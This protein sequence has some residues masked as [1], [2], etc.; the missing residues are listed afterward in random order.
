MATT[1]TSKVLLASAV[2]GM[3][4]LT[5]FGASAEEAKSAKGE[6]V[7]CYGVNECKGH[8]ACAGPNGCA[9]KNDCKGQGFIDVDSKEACLKMEGGRLT[10]NK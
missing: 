3:L 9:G 6:K 8:S 4:A 10:P 1:S 5:S 2:A 7:H